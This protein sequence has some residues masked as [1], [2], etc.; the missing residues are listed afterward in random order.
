MNRKK[1]QPGEPDVI[2]T[3]WMS[4]S[5]RGILCMMILAAIIGL[6][7]ILIFNIG[8][9]AKSGCYYKPNNL[10]VHIK[11]KQRSRI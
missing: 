4:F 7:T 5:Y 11:K 6:F 10:E 1:Q 9:D 3:K 8:Y 2:K